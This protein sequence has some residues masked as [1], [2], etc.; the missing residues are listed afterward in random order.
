MRLPLFRNAY[1]LMANQGVSSML[2]MAFWIAAARMFPADEVG[3][4]AALLSTIAF[5]ALLSQLGMRNAMAWVL[6]TI[7][8][9]AGR[10]IIASYG[11]SAA[12]TLVLAP[13]ILLTL[14]SDDATA[15]LV[16][17]GVAFVVWFTAASI[18]SSV[19]G[20]QDGVLVGLR[21]A[22]W[23]PVENALFGVLK[24]ALLPAFASISL[25]IFA[26]WTLAIPPLVIGVNVLIFSRLLA[27]RRG[28][29]SAARMPLRH[30]VGFISGDYIGNLMLQGTVA[31]IPILVIGILG[32]VAN[33][34]SFQ[35]WTVSQA[36][37]MV[38]GSMTSSLTVEALTTPANAVDYARRMLINIV[39]LLVPLSI[40]IAL[41]A[42][43]LLELFGPAYADEASD[44]LRVL[45]LSTLPITLNT[46]YYALCRIRGTVMPILVLRGIVTSVAIA[47]SIVLIP[48]VGITGTGI[49]WI[50]G[51]SLA[52]VIVIGREFRW[53]RGIGLK[54]PAGGLERVQDAS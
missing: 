29:R 51:Q 33:A 40:A 22:T 12:L 28:M 44:L 7:G 37:F 5:I 50:A 26:A 1:A 30:M 54:W 24:I 46:W 21:S 34:Y 19:F 27:S 43:L 17:G 48:I 42:P 15:K 14:A 49:G 32:T 2:G 41:G 6:P 35:A 11:I 31:L 39:R 47:L 45:A 23:V 16:Q 38:A 18:L 52:A 53:E 36:L 20:L 9:A 3:A 25:G 10:F 4:N 13:V 8:R